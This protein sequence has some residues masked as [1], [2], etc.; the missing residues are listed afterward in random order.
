MAQAELFVFLLIA[1]AILAGLARKLDVP[2]PVAL[3]IGGLAIG[4]APGLPSPRLDP[5]VVFFAFLPPLLYSAAFLASAYELRENAQPIGL[6][7]IG[8]VLVT[9]VGIAAVAHWLIGVP[10]VAGFVLGAVLGPTDPVAATTVIRR[11]GAPNRIETILEGESLVN[12]GTGLTAYKVATA[13]AGASVSIPGAAGKF[14]AIGLGGAAVGLA[15]GWIFSRLRAAIDDSLLDVVLSLLTPFAAYVPAEKV[16]ASGVLAVVTAGLLVG[17]R[18]LDI[19]EAETRLRT[20]SFWE[21]LSFL[22]NSLLFLLI[23]LQLPSIVDRIQGSSHA[24][25]VG[26]AL[27]IAGVT[28]AIRVVWMFTVPPLISALARVSRVEPSDT[29]ARERL[30]LGWSGMRGA[31]SLAAALAIPDNVPQRDLLIALSFGVVVATLV[32]PSATL[33]TLVRRLGLGQGEERRR[34]EAEARARLAHVALGRLEEAA[35]EAPRSERAIDLLRA[36]YETRL[37]AAESHSGSADRGDAEALGEELLTA[38]RD[39]LGEMRRE[40]AYPADLLRTLEREL[41]LEESRLRGRS[42]G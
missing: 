27:L 9:V 5:D 11:L 42:R 2:Y 8:L 36:R 40:R 17:H 15:V 34:D 25:L 4:I 38:Q 1:V 39:D 28:V 12:D 7:S 30:V 14:V 18:S 3:V 20:L 6:L 19:T 24:T 13:A 41:D 21:S 16:G 37:D 29:N 31:V 10:W 32:I 33:A 26:E 23:G 22:L 35:H